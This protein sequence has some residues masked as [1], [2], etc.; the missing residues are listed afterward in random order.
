MDARDIEI[1]LESKMISDVLEKFSITNRYG[2]EIVGEIRIPKNPIGCSFVIH[3]LGGFKE[4]PNTMAMVDTLFD[5]N[6]VVINFDATNSF[7]ESGGKYENATMQL[8]YEDLVDVINWTK[9]QSWYREPFVL[10]GRDLLLVTIK[11]VC[12]G[13]SPV[14]T[15]W[16]NA[17][18]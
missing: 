16:S 11:T 5:N 7:G 12:S 2:L 1:R 15:Y 10:A 13:N 6:Y 17:S 14:R 3:G 4:Q 18:G 9:E 8:H